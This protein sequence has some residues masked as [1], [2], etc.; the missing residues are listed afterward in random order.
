MLASMTGFG[1]AVVEAPFG[2]I[3]VEIQSVNRKHVEMSVSIPREYSR[4]ELDIRKLVSEHISRGQ[5]SIRVHVMPNSSD[6]HA[7]F[8]FTHQLKQFKQAWQQ[9]AVDLGYESTEIT[10]SFLVEQLS[11]RSLGEVAHD[12][13]LIFFQKAANQAIGALL[14]MKQ[15]EGAVLCQDIEQRL[16][17]MER[18][19]QDI[20][21]LAPEAIARMKKKL[22]ERIAE[23]ALALVDGE[24]RVLREIAIFGEKVDITEEII[25]LRS[26]IVQFQD[27]LKKPAAAGRKMEFLVQEMGREANTIGSKS[28]EAKITH[29]VV[30]VK[31]ELDKI[32]EQIQNIE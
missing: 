8:P 12:E 20:E 25:R 14:A 24:E 19:I 7:L 5:L 22:Q 9:L 31:S 10:L 1:R 23:V 26:H 11:M 28:L 30:E 6:L 13:D 17:L 27:L 3:I 21:A 29:L 18:Y 16:S 15:K 4:F 2:K 32:K